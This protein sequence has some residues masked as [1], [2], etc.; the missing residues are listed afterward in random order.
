[1]P[2]IMDLLVFSCVHY[3]LLF[4]LALI[5]YVIGQ[6]LTRTCI[7]NSGSEKTAFSISL[8]LGVVAC[9]IFVLGLL[10]L[11]YKQI[12]IFSLVSI[13]ILCLL[14]GKA[15][16]RDLFGL[17][18]TLRTHKLR[19]I[20]GVLC[21]FF[22]PYFLLPLYPPTAFDA[23]MYH[24]PSAIA[25]AQN[26]SL[27]FL[28]LVRFSLFPQINEM[29]FPLVLILSDDVS[30]HLVQFLM[31]GLVALG[32]YA[33]GQRLFNSR[34]SCWAAGTLAFKSFGSMDWEFGVHRYWLCMLYLFWY[35]RVFQLDGYR[36]DSVARYGGCIFR[37]W[38]CGE[39][40]SPFLFSFIR[41]GPC[42]QG[43]KETKIRTDSSLH[44]NSRAHSR[45]VVSACLLL[46]R[47]SGFP[48]FPRYL[49]IRILQ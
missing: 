17:L 13:T 3:G 27:V 44:N 18:A 23:T 46:Y 20:L 1:M 31:M 24:L 48:F 29:L 37:I 6:K 45:S 15:V 26:H 39:V 11:L 4:L 7:F 8:G 14:N 21:V 38:R 49:R 30:A 35:L 28:P 32:L 33:W 34:V 22:L 25:Y 40:F 10:H 19:L 42:F 2:G 9:V 36:C 12:V 43:D 5:S 41:F 47:Q 16:R